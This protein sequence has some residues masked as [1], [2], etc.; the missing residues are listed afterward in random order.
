MPLAPA[1]RTGELNRRPKK[2]GNLGCRFHL[3][4][5]CLTCSNQAAGPLPELPFPEL[6]LP[7][8]P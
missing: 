8:L 2:N 1:N 6:P 3:G 5:A 7:E 4:D